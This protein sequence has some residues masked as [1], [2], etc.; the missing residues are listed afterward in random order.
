[1]ARNYY[2]LA[3]ALTFSVAV[4]LLSGLVMG[5]LQAGRLVAGA[6]W[7]VATVAWI[8]CYVYCHRTERFRRLASV[9][10]RVSK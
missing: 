1:M 10:A 9:P 8:S 4:L 7:S 6:F 5:D 2:L 3:A